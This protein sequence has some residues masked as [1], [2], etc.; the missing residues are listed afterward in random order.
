VLVHFFCS[1]QLVVLVGSW[2]LVY[3][4]EWVPAA[5]LSGDCVVSARPRRCERK[6]GTWIY[7][8]TLTEIVSDFDISGGVR[9]CEK[10]IDRLP[11]S[12]EMLSCMQQPAVQLCSVLCLDHYLLTHSSSCVYL[13]LL[14]KCI[15]FTLEFTSAKEVNTSLRV[16]CD[17]NVASARLHNAP[18][19]PLWVRK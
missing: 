18:A 10:P 5:S 2:Q 9:P 19:N 8:E 4:S 7:K 13:N 11:Q 1:I 17:L 15:S 6:R 14:N 3:I 16:K 12:D